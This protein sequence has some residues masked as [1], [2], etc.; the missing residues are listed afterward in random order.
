LFAFSACKAYEEVSANELLT[1]LEELA[2]NEAVIANELVIDL[3]ELMANDAVPNKEPLNAPVK[4]PVLYD[5]VNALNEEVVTKDPVFTFCTG[6]LVNPL[7]SPVKL[8]VKLPVLYDEVNKLNELV[9]TKDPVL[10]NEPEPAGP[11][12]P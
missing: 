8:P 11:G 10:T 7:P 1:A 9:V 2:A 6:K 12:G 4:L 5:E 3:E